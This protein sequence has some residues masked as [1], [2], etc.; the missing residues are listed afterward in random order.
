MAT[1]E[2][3]QTRL[4]EAETAY[5]NLVLGKAMVEFRDSNGELVRYSQ[6]NR[7][8]LAAYIDDLKRQLGT[9]DISGPMR[10]MFR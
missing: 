7:A 5:H 3:L 10:S 4:T 1:T 8:A 9:Q 6:T 2:E